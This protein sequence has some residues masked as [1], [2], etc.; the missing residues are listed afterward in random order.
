MFL[1]QY[2]QVILPQ[3]MYSQINA[4]ALTSD[5]QKR[6]RSVEKYK[7]FLYKSDVPLTGKR[8][9]HFNLTVMAVCL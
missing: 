5:L 3:E 1:P 2:H 6:L 9:E 4:L 8:E 7:G